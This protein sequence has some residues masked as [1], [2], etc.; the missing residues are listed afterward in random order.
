M[1]SLATFGSHSFF[2]S[3]EPNRRS[4]SPRPI[5]WWADSSVEIAAWYM[6]AIASASL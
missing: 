3:S 5:D 6:P 1:W 4:G 2:C